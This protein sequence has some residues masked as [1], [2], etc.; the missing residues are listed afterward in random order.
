MGTDGTGNCGGLSQLGWDDADAA[1]GLVTGGSWK[2]G[3]HDAGALAMLL[4]AGALDA[5]KNL[6]LYVVDV[7]VIVFALVAVEFAL[8]ILVCCVGF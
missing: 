5:L 2:A 7:I 3:P 4:E 1:I 8:L 6:A